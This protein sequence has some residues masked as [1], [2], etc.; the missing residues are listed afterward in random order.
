MFQLGWEKGRGKRNWAQSS[1]QTTQN[2]AQFRARMTMSAFTRQR[3]KFGHNPA[4]ERNEVRAQFCGRSMKTWVQIYK[5]FYI[6]CLQTQQQLHFVNG[7]TKLKNK[8]IYI[9]IRAGRCVDRAGRKTVRAGRSAL[10]NRLS[11]NTGVSS[12]VPRCLYRSKSY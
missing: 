10:R 2:R 3:P 6:G 1:T 9:L 12:L 7:K 4:R 5:H 8:N 11:W